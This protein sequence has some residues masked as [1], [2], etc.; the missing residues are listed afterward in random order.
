M[1]PAVASLKAVRSMP[2]PLQDRKPLI[3][4]ADPVLGAARVAA[5]EG[6]SMQTTS[7]RRTQAYST[8]WK[9]ALV[10][11]QAIGAGLDPLPETADELRAVAKA[12][13]GAVEDIHLGASATETAIKDKKL[14]DYRVIYF[15]THGLVA[16]ELKGLAEPALVLS[17]PQA[18]TSR[19]D[20]LLTA[21]EVAQL[22]LDADWVVLSACNTAAANKAGAEAF[23]GLARAF[24][25][26]GARSLLVSHWPVDS[27]SAVR[28][29][30]GLFERLKEN[31]RGG[32]AEALR[33]S[34]LALMSDPSDVLNAHPAFWGPFTVVGESGS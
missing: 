20:G 33:A 12:V 25:Y 4:F 18:G 10:D 14:S 28:L 22:K 30:T 8:S 2:Q 5:R 13:G 11:V 26:A 7:L 3:G 16:G 9:G 1:L 24:F 29:T 31:A 15:A 17:V 6:R 34:M 19:D 32:R 21:S 23:S 27:P